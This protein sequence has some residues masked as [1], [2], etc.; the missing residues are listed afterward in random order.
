[1]WNCESSIRLITLSLIRRMSRICLPSLCGLMNYT[2][3]VT[4]AYPTWNGSNLP[5]PIQPNPQ[6]YTDQIQSNP[7]SVSVFRPTSTP[8]KRRKHCPLYREICSTF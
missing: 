8:I 7:L 4:V 3:T 2:V 6:T 1:M 5:D